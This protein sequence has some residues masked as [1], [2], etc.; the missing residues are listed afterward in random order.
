VFV[1][2]GHEPGHGTPPAAAIRWSVDAFGVYAHVGIAVKVADSRV[3][4]L[5]YDPVARKK[6][7]RKK[8]PRKKPRHLMSEAARMMV[9]ARYHRMTPEQRRELARKAARA[10]WGKR[11]G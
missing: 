11:K 7:P 2:A 3:G 5:R 1:H 9:R 4:M 10:R 8:R 6:R